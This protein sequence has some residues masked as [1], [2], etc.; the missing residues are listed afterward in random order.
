MTNMAREGRRVLPSCRPP[1]CKEAIRLKDKHFRH[2]FLGDFLIYGLTALAFITL[3][4]W[5]FGYRWP[6]TPF[7]SQIAHIIDGRA[8]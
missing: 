8:A 1:I 6:H 4:V 2:H 5:A 7:A 3:W